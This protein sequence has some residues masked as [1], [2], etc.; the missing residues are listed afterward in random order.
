MV[1]LCLCAAAR[2]KKPI[3][4][5]S[6]RTVIVLTLLPESVW[7]SVVSVANE[8]RHIFFALQH[9]AVPFCE[10]VWPT[11]SR[12]SRCCSEKFPLHKNSTYSWPGQLSRAEIW[13]TDLLERWHPRT[14][15]CW[16]SPSSS[17]SPLYCQCFVWRL[18]GCGRNCIHL[19]ATG[20]AEIAES[21]HLNGFTHTFVYIVHSCKMEQ[22]HWSGK[23]LSFR[24]S[25]MFS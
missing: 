6:W 4:W 2:P 19:S 10:L 7:N 23:Q 13:W 9:S 17:V 8:D 12:L 25:E 5:S 20:V 11:T 24:F 18:H 15:P 22:C 21:T 3:S 1:F 14:V 16:K